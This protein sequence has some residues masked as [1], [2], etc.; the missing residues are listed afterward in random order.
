MPEHMGK[1]LNLVAQSRSH[2][3][4]HSHFRVTCSEENEGYIILPVRSVFCV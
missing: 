4:D 3:V 1:F 2:K